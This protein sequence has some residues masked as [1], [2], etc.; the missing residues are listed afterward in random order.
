MSLASRTNF[1]RKH[2]RQ[3]DAI[4]TAL[5]Q[6][7]Q[8]F[9]MIP[10]IDIVRGNSEGTRYGDA[11]NFSSLDLNFHITSNLQYRRN[12]KKEQL[13]EYS[14]SI[15]QYQD[16]SLGIRTDNYYT[17]SSGLQWSFI[18]PVPTDASGEGLQTPLTS[19]TTNVPVQNALV[20]STLTNT[21]LSETTGYYNDHITRRYF[22]YSR[23]EKQ[24]PGNILRMMVV[25]CD[26]IFDTSVDKGDLFFD[27][28]NTIRNPYNG[29]NSGN[30]IPV[31]SHFNTTG[32]NQ[33]DIVWEKYFHLDEN[34]DLFYRVS[35]PVSGMRS[36][37]S[38]GATSPTYNDFNITPRTFI[39]P[40][41]NNLYLIYM[42]NCTYGFTNYTDL[43]SEPTYGPISCTWLI[44]T[45]WQLTWRDI[46]SNAN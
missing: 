35:I 27:V 36:K 5:T 32:F 40:M 21:V 44:D 12:E 18:A 29:L 16:N 25:R 20:K 38:E 26:N 15:V 43:Y 22:N 4:T 6:R 23:T 14:S 46:A 11:A 42:S 8:L 45:N 2:Y 30:N 33:L 28:K 41:Y 24:R 1:S 39:E 34:P 7:Y 10:L 31:G 13:P 37:W 3:Y 19:V 17:S 9:R